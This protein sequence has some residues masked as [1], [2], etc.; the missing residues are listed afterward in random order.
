MSFT[1]L[2]RIDWKEPGVAVTNPDQE[3]LPEDAE[4]GEGNTPSPDSPED[5]DAQQSPEVPL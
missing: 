1:S 3:P 4:E 5:D 2:P